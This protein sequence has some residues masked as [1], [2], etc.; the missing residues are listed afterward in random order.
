M[1]FVTRTLL[2]SPRERQARVRASQRGN[3]ERISRGV[4]WDPAAVLTE[5]HDLAA[6]S[7]SMPRAVICL[8]SALQVEELT[9]QWPREVWLALPRGGRVPTSLSLPVRVHW[10]SASMLEL[11]VQL[12]LFEGQSVRVTSA[13]RTVLDFF[14]YRNSYGIDVAVEA[15]KDY[16]ARSNRNLQELARLSKLLKMDRVVA[17]YLQALL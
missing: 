12:H 15:L 9:T 1:Q 2:K 11:G 3:L 4:Y 14:R 6:A 16:L 10:W 5:H 13:E 8:F 7:A 17:P